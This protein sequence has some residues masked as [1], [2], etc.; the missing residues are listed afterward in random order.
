M[1][2]PIHVAPCAPLPSPTSYSYSPSPMC[3]VY[4]RDSIASYAPIPSASS[5]ASCSVEGLG[6][7]FPGV[8]S[9]RPNSFEI[10]FPEHGRPLRKPGLSAS[11]PAK[12][13]VHGAPH[14][15]HRI[16]CYGDSITAGFYAGGK[17]FQPYGQSLAEAL[18]ADGVPCESLV[19][20]LTGLTAVD[21]AKNTHAETIQD[22]VGYPGQGLAKILKD[23]SPCDLAILLI[24]TN[25]LGT[26][27]PPQVAM[28]HIAQLHIDC[29]D[30]NVATV[31][32]A[33]PTLPRGPQRADREHLVELLA[34]WCSKTP[35]VVALFDAE[36]LIPNVP[37][38][39]L[40]D[41]DEIHL[42]AMGSI[43][44]GHRLAAPVA[45]FL[46]HGAPQHAAAA[47]GLHRLGGRAPRRAA[48]A[49]G[50]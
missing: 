29:H 25:D 2:L 28:Q 18:I 23:N 33:P 15:S 36:E 21:L 34:S 26:G 47:A 43:K 4:R 40:W 19:C 49:G 8:S 11:C 42:S 20:G 9:C 10:L 44:L 50:A 31:A 12:F 24:G 45:R 14:F 7:E 3:N 27:V 41:P 13:G 46:R 22:M 16:L 5:A 1:L 17:H 35:G 37:G 30:R 6:L 32:I 39:G 38:S 48:R